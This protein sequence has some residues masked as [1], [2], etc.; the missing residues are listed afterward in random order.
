MKKTL[1]VA[2]VVSGLLLGGC[3][4]DKNGDDIPGN[5]TLT[6]GNYGFDGGSSGKFSST[7]A[8]F[9]KSQATTGGGS[10]TTNVLTISG[11]K[12]GGKEAIVI[13]IFY[14]GTL[15]T[16]NMKLGAAYT[17]GNVAIIKD[18]TDPRATTYSTNNSGT[19]GGGVAEVVITK[20]DGDNIEGTFTVFS[21]YNSSQK[22]AFAEQ[23]T[24]SGTIK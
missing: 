18:N 20:V 2:F 17:S 15:A 24:F 13:A 3:K 10:T 11:T 23:G 9:I 5:S 12:D 7:T 8:T 22:Q 19:A 1:L 6:A 4:K 21:A 16:G 14:T